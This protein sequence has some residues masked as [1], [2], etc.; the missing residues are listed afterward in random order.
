MIFCTALSQGTSVGCITTTQNWKGNHFK[1]INPLFLE[2]KNPRKS[3][4]PENAC[5]QFS[6]TTER[7]TWSEVRESTGGGGEL[8]LLQHN[9]RLH[10]SAATS[11]ATESIRFEVVPHSPYS[12]D[13]VLSD[14]WL[15]GASKTHLKGNCSTHDAQ[16]PSCYGKM[17]S[18]TAWKILHW[19]VLKTC[20]WAGRVVWM[21]RTTWKR[22]V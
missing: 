5:S 8:M 6:G 21:R 4:P 16:V 13:L 11:A 15:F 7:V 14:F 20:S 18:R 12:P 2:V 9:T 3:L 17:V 19:Q 10:T 1:I 22:D